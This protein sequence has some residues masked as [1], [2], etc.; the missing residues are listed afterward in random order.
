M[1]EA[2]GHISQATK[3]YNN[4]GFTIIA[5]HVDNA[6]ESLRP[7]LGE[8]NLYIVARDGHVPQIER[9]IRTIKEHG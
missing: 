2:L 6:L 9:S 8:A 1:K 4:R 3:K 7:H 5:Y